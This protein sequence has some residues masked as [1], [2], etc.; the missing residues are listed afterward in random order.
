MKQSDLYF[1]EDAIK[2]LNIILATHG[3]IP[4]FVNGE[5]GSEQMIVPRNSNFSV[6]E[7]TVEL[8]R[9]FEYVNENFQDVIKTHDMVCAIGGW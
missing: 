8:G 1:I 9:N 2:E 5:Y 3:N 7:A 6:G 4:V